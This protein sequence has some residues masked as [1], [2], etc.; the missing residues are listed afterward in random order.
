MTEMIVAHLADGGIGMADYT[1]ALEK[2][3]SAAINSGETR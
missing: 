1:I 3:F 2:V